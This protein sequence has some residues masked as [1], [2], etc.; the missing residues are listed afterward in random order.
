MPELSDYQ[1]AAC[2]WASLA[3]TGVIAPM[4]A[5]GVCSLLKRVSPNR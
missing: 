5:G 4:L 3:L 1:F 2:F